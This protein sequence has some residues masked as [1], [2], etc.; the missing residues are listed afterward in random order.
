MTAADAYAALGYT[1]GGLILLGVAA[2]AASLLHRDR[3]VPGLPDDG[4]GC[5]TEE[6]FLEFL[7]IALKEDQAD[8]EP[9][10]SA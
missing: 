3:H 4:K 7:I 9:E 5:M 1:L 10:R 8:P 6:E 2:I